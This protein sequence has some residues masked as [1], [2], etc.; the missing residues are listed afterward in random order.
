MSLAYD[1]G[2]VRQQC[3]IC[4]TTRVVGG[5]LRTSSETKEVRFVGPAELDQLNMHPSMRLRIKHY[6]E[7]HR[8]AGVRCARPPRRASGVIG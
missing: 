6:L 7:R 5:E 3:S 2:E 4:F 1:D 8:R